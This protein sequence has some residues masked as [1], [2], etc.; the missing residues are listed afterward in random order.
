MTI[1]LIR[2]TKVLEQ[3]YQEFYWEWKRSGEKLIPSIIEKFPDDIDCFLQFIDNNEKG[4]NLPDGWVPDSTFWLVKGK[5][6]IGVVNIRHQLT[7]MLLTI[8]GHIGYGIRPSERRKGYATKILELALLEAKRVD[9]NKA[10]VTCDADNIGSLKAILKNGG[11]E[12]EEFIEDD[13]NVVKR[14]WIEL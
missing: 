6:I 11:I 10:L 14:F 7:E 5:L 9:I 12:D 2:P 13:G 8:G 3:E 4:K 1:Q